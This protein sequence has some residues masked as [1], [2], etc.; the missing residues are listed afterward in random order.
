MNLTQLARKLS[1]F[2]MIEILREGEVFILLIS[3]EKLTSMDTFM[4]IQK[5]ITDYTKDKFPFVEAMTNTDYLYCVV[6]K[7]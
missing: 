7:K 6:L 1:K 4:G 5:L 2:G 3:G